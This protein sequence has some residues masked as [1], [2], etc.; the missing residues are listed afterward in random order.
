[1]I[2]DDDVGMAETCA[3]LLEAYGFEVRTASSGAE[4]LTKLDGKSPELL[5]ADAEVPGM[6][7]SELCAKINRQVIAAPVPMLMISASARSA[8]PSMQNYDAFLRKPFLAE[9]F[10][11]AIDGLLPGVCTRSNNL[12]R[13]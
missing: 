12:V 8:I 11:G 9:S 4:A 10:L 1:M 13:Q 7:G 6:S 5:I 3:M 2:V